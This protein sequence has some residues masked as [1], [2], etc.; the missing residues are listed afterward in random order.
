M[1]FVKMGKILKM[2][3]FGYRSKRKGFNSLKN[4]GII[5]IYLKG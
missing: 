3:M 4:I 5:N 2:G 1:F